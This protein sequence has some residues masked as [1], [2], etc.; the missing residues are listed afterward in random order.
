ML[1]RRT[2]LADAMRRLGA[3]LKASDATVA[4]RNAL[5]EAIGDP[6]LQLM[7]RDTRSGKWNDP[8][9]CDADAPPASTARRAVTTIRDDD[10][11]PQVALVH[12]VALRDDEELL[13]DATDLVL[14]SLRH[15][16]LVNSLVTALGD[17]E[18]S[19][20][21]MAEAAL[22]E[23]ARIERDLHDGAQQQLIALR[24]RADIAEELLK[25]DPAASIEEIRKLAYHAD[26]ALAEL[27]SCARGIYPALLSDRG[28]IEALR[29]IG[30]EAPIPVRIR[31]RGVE[32]HPIEIESAVYFTCV[33]AIQNAAK[34]ATGAT[35]VWLALTE[36]CGALHFTVKD[37]GCGFDLHTADGHGLRNMRDR[38]EAEGG[39]L[40][41]DTSPGCG[42]RLIGDLDVTRR[43]ATPA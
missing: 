26:R 33:E 42:A 4:V 13:E 16:Q 10:G 40:S 20:Q 31:S 30:R 37:D 25:T 23:R 1:W 27:R 24:I 39:H 6:T 41:F 34:H 21:R 8:S 35:G 38:I 22:L 9:G 2:L 7:I 29:S 32:R 12:D 14:A 28:L 43:P 3:A 18:A 36:S 17:L 15:D 19:R 5:A 11:E